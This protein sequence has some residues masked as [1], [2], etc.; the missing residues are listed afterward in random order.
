M[1]EDPICQGHKDPQE[2]RLNEIFK[3][4]FQSFL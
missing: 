3:S 2:Q 1:G 4:N